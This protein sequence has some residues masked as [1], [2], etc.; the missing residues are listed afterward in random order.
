MKT[1]LIACFPN[2]DINDRPLCLSSFVSADSFETA[3]KRF[4]R[5][6]GNSILIEKLEIKPIVNGDVKSKDWLV[7]A[8]Y[9][10]AIDGEIDG[11][12]EF[13]L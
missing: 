3:E 13:S 11:R 5:V 2:E 8:V 9:E 1:G 10:K 7:H 4:R 6:F 12:I